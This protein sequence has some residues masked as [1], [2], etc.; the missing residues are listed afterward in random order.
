MGAVDQNR[1]DR[2]GDVL[3][4]N[5]VRA[6]SDVESDVAAGNGETIAGAD[7]T[8]DASDQAEQNRVAA[9]AIDDEEVANRRQDEAGP[10]AARQAVHRRVRTRAALDLDQVAQYA[11][12]PVNLEA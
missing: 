8:G 1:A 3:Q 7:H 12:G 10:G 6:V 11:G 2:G 5:V 4:L 9:I